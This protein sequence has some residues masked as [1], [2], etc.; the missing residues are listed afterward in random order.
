[1][2]VFSPK[3]LAQNSPVYV[4]LQKFPEI[5]ASQFCHPIFEDNMTAT[6]TPIGTK[7][8]KAAYKDLYE[9]GEIGVPSA[10]QT[11]L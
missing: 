4:A 8:G 3:S 9:I 11:P 5:I 1:L 6:V 2:L 7:D 10:A